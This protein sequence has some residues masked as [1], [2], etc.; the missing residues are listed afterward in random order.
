[1][2][3]YR[4]SLH[5]DK[6]GGFLATQR[7]KAPPLIHHGPVIRAELDQLDDRT[8]DL[9]E[10]RSAPL[11]Q[12]LRTKRASTKTPEKHAPPPPAPIPAWAR[13]GGRA[14]EGD[15][16]FF[17]GASLALLDAYLRRDPPSAGSTA[18]MASE[19]SSPT[20]RPPPAG[21]NG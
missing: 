3:A 19:S 7:D 12:P 16:L 13:A 11:R 4:T 2:E 10:R 14:R 5:S 18:T 1:M 6:R 8:P 9:Q 21:A 17:A 15:P 20:C